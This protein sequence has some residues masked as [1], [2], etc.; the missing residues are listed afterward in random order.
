MPRVTDE[1]RER[2]RQQILLAARRCFVRQ[3]FHQ[4][5]MADIFTEAGLSSGAVY[6][7][8]KSKDE[9]IAAIADDAV[10]GIIRL[11]EPIATRQPPPPVAEFVREALGATS[12]FAFGD[13]GI[14]RLAPQVW[15][16]AA[17]DPVLA[18]VLRGKY[19]KVQGVLS[20]LV[21]EEQRVGRIASNADPGAV[22][23]VLISMITGFI[24]QRVLI[25][26]I[27]ADDFA[28]GLAAIA[29]SPGQA[30]PPPR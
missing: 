8:F 2:R 18:E 29:P 20:G 23:A 6:G 30:L 3:G 21:V 9:L 24:L 13:D 26:K 16:E 17:R 15:A 25:G 27:G 7:Y 5:S 28:A 1:H 11:I 4:T 14:A 22:A 12:E 10:S 19:G